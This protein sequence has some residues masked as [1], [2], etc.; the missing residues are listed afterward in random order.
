[1]L[2]AFLNYRN[3]LKIAVAGT[4]KYRVQIG[5]N[6]QERSV[7]LREHCWLESFINLFIS[8]GIR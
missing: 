7:G 8:K 6:E 4:I 1:M 2:L 3:C 5:V